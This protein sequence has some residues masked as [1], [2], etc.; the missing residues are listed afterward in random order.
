MFLTTLKHEVSLRIAAAFILSLCAT[1]GLAQTLAE[2]DVF[3]VEEIRTMQIKGD[4]LQYAY[5]L[6]CD[7]TEVG[8]FAQPINKV[9][10]LRLAVL[11]HQSGVRCAGMPAPVVK[12]I[13]LIKFSGLEQ[14]IKM[15]PVRITGKV[16]LGRVAS[17]RQVGEGRSIEAIWRQS[18]ATLQGFVLQQQHAHVLGL[19]LLESAT[20]KDLENCKA[21][22]KILRPSFIA[23]Q[24]IDSLYAL[25]DNLPV[26]Q[27]FHLRVA[28]IVP[29]SLARQVGGDG[30]AFKYERRCNE[31]PVGV[32][33]ARPMRKGDM[34]VGMVVAHFYNRPCDSH[35]PRSYQVEYSFA[36]YPLKP[37]VNLLSMPASKGF[38]DYSVRTP[39]QFGFLK[40]ELQV[41]FYGSC[42][43]AVGVIYA[44][45]ILD[46][47][48]I[49][50]LEQR[51]ANTECKKPT[52][53]LS[54]KQPYFLSNPQATGHYPMKVEG[55]TIF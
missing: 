26:E 47:T 15:D 2:R 13:S 42:Q 6:P 9:K 39:L 36:A 31:A 27:A 40:E 17:L 32:T 21:G 18:C 3:A 4:E 54:F 25:G 19:G 35:E 14:I 16:R 50:I 11:V 38:G 24:R 8:L 37:G 52:K 48:S 33:I 5:L 12:T 20:A 44:D 53:R 49:G 28:K 34:R 41:R 43:R 22:E 7:S 23:H 30:F 10:L 55:E 1:P 45:G 46:K 51:T 29:G